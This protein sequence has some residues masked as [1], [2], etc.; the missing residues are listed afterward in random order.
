MAISDAYTE[1]NRYITNNVLP[2]VEEVPEDRRT[3]LRQLAEAIRSHLTQKGG[4]KVV[5]ICTHNSRR[6]QFAQVWASVA[7]RWHGL[8]GVEFRS[9]GTEVTEINP[10]AIRALER[11][12]FAMQQEKGDNPVCA[13]RWSENGISTHCY[14]KLI[15]DAF[16]NT[17]PF[18][19]VMTCADADANCP[20]VP[21]ADQRI[22][23][24]YNDPKQA[25]GTAREQEVYDERCWQIATEMFWLMEE[26]ATMQK[27]NANEG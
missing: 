15:E 13:V 23:L 2:A 20:H 22:R 6:S 16:D 5:F 10:R 26:I 7:A 25:D 17:D 3:I 11:A 4:A 8:Q 1:L 24:L 18:I 9:G 19:A 14:S 27:E 21:E 12:G